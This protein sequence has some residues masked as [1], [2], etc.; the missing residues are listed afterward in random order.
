MSSFT[1]NP[2]EILP[3]VRRQTRYRQGCQTHP[4]KVYAGKSGKVERFTR[5]TYSTAFFVTTATLT[6]RVAFVSLTQATDA[7]TT[8]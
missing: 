2:R 7:T 3:R 5:S 8:D 1:G 6:D 4:V